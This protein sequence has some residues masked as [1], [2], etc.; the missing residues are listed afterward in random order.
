MATNK[1][2]GGANDG[3]WGTAG[4]WSGG[5][6][7]A[8]TEDIVIDVTSQS[9]TAGLNQTGVAIASLTVSSGVSIGGNGSSLVIGITG[10]YTHTGSGTVYISGDTGVQ[11]IALAKVVQTYGQTVYFTG[12]TVTELQVKSGANA[13]VQ[14]GCVVTT[15]RP[16]GSLIM[17]TNGTAVTTYEQGGG[18]AITYRNITTGTVSGSGSTLKAMTS[19]AIGT[20]LTV[21]GGARY[22]HLSSG[23]IANIDVWDLS[24]ATS[25]GSQYASFTVTNSTVRSGGYLFNTNR[26]PAVPTYTNPTAKVARVL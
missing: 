3:N 18:S 10:T 9:I 19:A 25:D 21:A 16:D 4:N 15:C 22:Y 8:N 14:A 12:G 6:I 23:T 17:E 2:T 11:A 26:E 1:W 20:K 24:T 7:P 5:H 13:Y